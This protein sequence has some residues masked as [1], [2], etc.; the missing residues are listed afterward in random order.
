[1]KRIDL[2]LALLFL[3]ILMSFT[4]DWVKYTSSKDFFSINFPGKPVENEQTISLGNEGMLV[5]TISTK[6]GERGYGITVML[7][8]ESVNLSSDSKEDAAKVFRSS[9]DGGVNNLGDGQLIS[10]MDIELDGYPGREFKI[11]FMGGKGLITGRI[12][13]VNK[14]IYLLQAATSIDDEGD[15]DIK[16]FI[17]SFQLMSRQN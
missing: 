2:F 8:P 6:I 1:M 3:P 9:I 11:T 13:F 15:A 4:P 7:Y 5:K 17:N 10:E 12:Y 16:R 14:H